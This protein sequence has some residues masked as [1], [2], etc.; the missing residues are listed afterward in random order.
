MI[1]GLAIYHG[2]LFY[3]HFDVTFYK[4][5]LGKP[6]VVHDLK[7]FDEALYASL[8]KVQQAE[9]VDDW[10]LTFVATVKDENGDPKEI[11]L[12]PDGENIKVTNENKQEFLELT[13]RFFLDSTKEQ[14]EAIRNGLHRFVPK[15][16]L[17]E[18]EPDEIDLLIGGVEP[19]L[20]DLR[21]NTQ[22]IDPYCDNNAN[23]VNLN[24]PPNATVP[25]PPAHPVIKMFWE[26]VSQFNNEEL[27]R[28]I[29]FTTGSDKVPIGG[30]KHLIGSS[31]PQPFTIVP[32]KVTGLP[33]AHSCFNRLELPAYTDKTSMK[34]DLLLAINET[35][36][37]GLE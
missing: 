26:I 10:E 33:T 18:F 36:G 31:G 6:L 9:S 15:E 13:V 3:G 20:N 22:Y 27:K 11:E 1:L 8:K 30:F 12:K 35:T 25:P 14:M 19:D 4:S 16:L 7:H 28:L 29:K 17:T 24:A 2:K 5:L 32:K 21:L 23:T 34:R 37:F